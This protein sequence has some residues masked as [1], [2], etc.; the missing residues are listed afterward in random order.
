MSKKL[1]LYFSVYGT[2][3]AVAAVS[4]KTMAAISTGRLTRRILLMLFVF[5]ASISSMDRSIRSRK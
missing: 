1:V 2:A 5:M 4:A 3:K